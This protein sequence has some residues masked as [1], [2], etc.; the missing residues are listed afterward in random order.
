MLRLKGTECWR[1]A[2]C[3]VYCDVNSVCVCGI[4]LNPGHFFW[5]CLFSD[6]LRLGNCFP[7]RSPSELSRI[8]A[9][10]Y[11]DDRWCDQKLFKLWWYLLIFGGEDALL[12]TKGGQAWTMSTQCGPLPVRNLVLYNSTLQRQRRRFRCVVYKFHVHLTLNPLFAVFSMVLV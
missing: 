9:L 1:C 3:T 7:S 8:S 4:G 12:S 5:N 10:S 11:L 2:V 6:T